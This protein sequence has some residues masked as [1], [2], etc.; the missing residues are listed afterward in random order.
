MKKYLRP[1]YTSKVGVAFRN[2]LNIRPPVF[3]YEHQAAYLSS[4]LFIWR[5]DC[6]FTTVFK[7]SDILKKYY[8]IDSYL[9]LVI[10]DSAG[11]HIGTHDIEFYE[12]TLTFLIDKKTVGREGH[13]TFCAINLP[14]RRNLNP[15]TF[16]VIN[17]CYVGYGVNGSY[18]MVHGN[19]VGVWVDPKIPPDEIQYN[20]T[21]AANSKRGKYTYMIQDSFSHSIELSLMFSN[22]LKRHI[23]LKVNGQTHTIEPM[24]S[25]IQVNGHLYD[26][27]GV[28]TI[29]SDF[30]FPRPLIIVKDG[31][32]ID[33][34]HG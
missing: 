18:S 15:P 17:R 27:N 16:N 9:K 10:Y 1:L 32:F 3:T 19:L 33:C 30:I 4:D 20:L 21:P 13:G 8:E 28:V 11:N 6:G 24:G 26:R 29:Q 31:I 34:H 7:A 2:F 22:P 23:K 14:A 25:L 5:T 12:G